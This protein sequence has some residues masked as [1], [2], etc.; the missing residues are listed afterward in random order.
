M[1][2]CKIHNNSLGKAVLVTSWEE[3]RATII[4]WFNEQFDRP[5]T[6]EEVANLD[7]DQEICNDE[8]MDNTY[9]FSFNTFT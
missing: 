7:L 1:F 3:G 9:T 8:D 5:M 4:K 6:E 2:V